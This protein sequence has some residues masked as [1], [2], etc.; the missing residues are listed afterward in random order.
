MSGQEVKTIDSGLLCP[1]CREPLRPKVLGCDGC[2]I[3]VEGP[4]Q[5]N[6]FATLSAEDLHF[7]RIFVHSEG[8]IREMQ[9]ALGL[10]YPTV[11][12]RLT[13]LK[14]R[15][16]GGFAAPPSAPGSDDGS[17]PG[18]GEEGAKRVLDRLQTGELTFEEA[19]EAIRALPKQKGKGEHR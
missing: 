6:E 15:I 11:R 16:S 8:R 9:A 3:R 2:G 1:S 4:F 13:A 14:N 7:L 18:A 10:S 17:P 12:A 19:M 5:L